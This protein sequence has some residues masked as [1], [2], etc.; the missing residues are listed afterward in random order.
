MGLLN[1][2]KALYSLISQLIT[3]R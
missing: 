2:W 3:L 1:R